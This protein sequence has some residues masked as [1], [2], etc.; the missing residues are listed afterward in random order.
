M[1]K[2]KAL[3]HG[4][5]LDI[6]SARE[7]EGLEIMADERQLKQVMFNLLSNAA[8]FTPDGG[9][10]TVEGRK[11][12]K[13]LIISVIQAQFGYG[14]KSSQILSVKVSQCDVRGSETIVVVHE[15][16]TYSSK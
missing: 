2:E 11:K 6:D 16:I 7:L 9:A 1:I 10:I 5:S 13:E 4:I 3:K 15:V 8:I 14:I 12:G